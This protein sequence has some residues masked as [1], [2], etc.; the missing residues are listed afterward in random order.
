[1]RQFRDA[2]GVEWQVFQA[3]RQASLGLRDEYL[4]ETYRH[5]WLV[6]ESATEKRRLAPVPDGWV[7]LPVTELR[8]LCAVA[9]PTRSRRDP[10][11]E[12]APRSDSR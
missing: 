1:M 9:T 8:R 11:V 6:F 5:G 7:A 4:P 12:A 3:E 2:A 10:P